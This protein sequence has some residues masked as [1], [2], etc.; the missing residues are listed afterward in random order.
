MLGD[1]LSTFIDPRIFGNGSSDFEIP[2]FLFAIRL[3][4]RFVYGTSG[5]KQRH[6]VRLTRMNSRFQR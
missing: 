5:E 4:N 2:S 3:S 1:E 6:R